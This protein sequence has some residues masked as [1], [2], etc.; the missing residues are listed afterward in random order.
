MSLCGGGGGGG[1]GGGGE[2]WAG[3]GT[4]T[5]AGGW[6][7]SA[8]VLI[9]ALQTKKGGRWPRLSGPLGPLGEP[10]ARHQR[11]GGEGAGGEEMSVQPLG[12][13]H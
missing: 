11:G 1:W 6:G 5:G 4:G 8:H 9:L 10:G 13:M 3:A 2:A 7:A 12:T